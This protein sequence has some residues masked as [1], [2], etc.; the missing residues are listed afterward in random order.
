MQRRIVVWSALP[1]CVRTLVLLLLCSHGWGCRAN[2][3]A[4]P[5]GVVDGGAADDGGG[6]GTGGGAPN[7]NG[8]VLGDTRP[9]TA[10]YVAKVK[11]LTCSQPATAQEV[12]AVVADANAL[13]PLVDTW[14]ASDA[15]RDKLIDFFGVAFQ[16]AD[17]SVNDLLVLPSASS[18]VYFRGPPTEFVRRQ[19]G[20]TAL[21]VV[22]AKQ[23]LTTLVSGQQLMMIPFLAA[24]CAFIDTKKEVMAAN[25][26]LSLTFTERVIS[27][28]VS[29]DPTSADYMHWTVPG[30]S[31]AKWN[32]PS[33]KQDPSVVDANTVNGHSR[34][35][36]LSALLGYVVGSPPSYYRFPDDAERLTCTVQSGWPQ[37]PYGPGDPN[38]W[39]MVQMRLPRP[40]EA[41][42]KF[43]DLHAMVQG[44]QFVMN[45]PRTGF[46]DTL[47]FQAKYPTNT[48]N[49]YRAAMNQSLVVALGQVFDGGDPTRPLSF[50]ALDAE[51][52]SPQG[53]CFGC[54][55]T[56]DPMRQFFRQSWDL[57][58]NS[59]ADLAMLA[60][61]G[62][63]AWDGLAEAGN[64][65][66]ALGQQLAA[67]PRFAKSWAQKACTYLRSGPCLDTDP[68]L[69]RIAALFAASNYDFDAL[70][71][72]LLASPLVTFAAPTATEADAGQV[73]AMNK[74]TQ[75]C[76]A[77]SLRHQVP[78]ICG[79]AFN[80]KVPKALAP[81]ATV[82]TVMP[83]DGYSRGSA[84]PYQT[85]DPSL[86]LLAGL[87][88]VCKA[89]AVVVVDG[90][91]SPYQ[92]TK[93]D[94]A[95]AS[96]VHGLVGID[97]SRDATPLEVLT[98]HYAAAVLPGVAPTKL[99]LDQKST[100]AAAP[101]ASLPQA[102]LD[103]SM[104]VHHATG[105]SSHADESRVLALMGSVTNGDSL[106]STLSTALQPP[107]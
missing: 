51:H 15:Y 50:A 54:H 53:A 104:F 67:S 81:V 48:S 102:T 26:N 91:N 56:L 78:V 101:W 74:Q 36:V 63:W 55:A 12:A 45:R 21:A 10:S 9:S 79:L 39:R 25:P 87:E 40:G 35:A 66:L 22:E 82:A 4:S 31:A 1:P 92:S 52:A 23:P 30:M 65:T 29:I 37:M 14:M 28:S 100:T 83:S 47:A 19:F 3:G 69:D 58:E 59:Q 68:E 106:S 32:D 44:T 86:P 64:F 20:R 73:F 105:T 8:V 80:S 5:K 18:A 76:Q 24:V 62:Q 71:R 43:Y 85:N 41:T 17:V 34:A 90:V 107:L 89:I 49:Q 77:L 93:S 98:G 57:Q 97:A 6:G 88:N 103:R 7:A 70:M 99:L 27:P 42:T 46:M 13:G 60:M 84:T 75:L 61:T 72:A 38:Q 95:I 16:Q 94:E 2:G 96:M 11:N 33:C